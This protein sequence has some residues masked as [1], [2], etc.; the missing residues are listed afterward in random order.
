MSGASLG[1]TVAPGRQTGEGRARR[2]AQAAEGGE[3][4][5]GGSPTPGEAPELRGL[6]RSEVW[7]WHSL[8]T[9]VGKAAESGGLRTEGPPWVQFC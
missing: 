2:G 3:R 8:T 4:G 6:E 7:F 9:H 1:C 5:Q